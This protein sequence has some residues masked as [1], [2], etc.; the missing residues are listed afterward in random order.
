MQNMSTVFWNNSFA[1]PEM[2]Y[3]GRRRGDNLCM[4]MEPE[5]GRGSHVN[6]CFRNNIMKHSR[7]MKNSGQI[8]LDECLLLLLLCPMEHKN[9]QLSVVGC[10]FIWWIC[11]MKVVAEIIKDVF[12]LLC[13]GLRG[14]D[15]TV[16]I[17]K[18]Q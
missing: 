15:C 10:A 8:W 2:K 9:L 16:A 14:Y 7:K 17:Q 5:A 1:F 18:M 6:L 13:T 11:A 3:F 4:P 12:L